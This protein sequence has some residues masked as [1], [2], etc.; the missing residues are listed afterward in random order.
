MSGAANALQGESGKKRRR[1]I[2][3]RGGNFADNRLMWP[4][5]QGLAR[6]GVPWEL[7]GPELA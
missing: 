3:E 7:Q 5:Q 4:G 6:H 1:R 2:P